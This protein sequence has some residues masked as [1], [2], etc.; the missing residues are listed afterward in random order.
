MRARTLYLHVGLPKTASTFLQERVFPQ[1][2]GLR[3]ACAPEAALFDAADPRA[4]HRVVQ[5]ALRR[6]A[7]VWD[8]MGDKIF[9]ALFGDRDACEAADWDAL[10]S[11]E[12]IGRIAN[13]PETFAAHLRAMAALGRAW[14]FP[15]TV[16][17]CLLRRQDQWIGS[18]YAQTSDA[19][20][21]AGQAHFEE[22]IARLLDPAAARHRLGTLLDYDGVVAAMEAA[23]GVEATHVM[24]YER[25][26]ADPDAFRRGL[27]T[28]LDRDPD[29]LAG[30]PAWSRR[31]NARSTAD[32]GWRLR[33]RHA[34]GPLGRLRAR[35][36][37]ERGSVRL[38]PALSARIRESYGPGN[39]RLAARR[40]DL[41]LEEH[42]YLPAP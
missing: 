28:A 20:A 30:A 22:E 21:G 40:P 23:L 39:R 9:H 8:S 3:A 19:V 5:A 31:A 11:E 27:M 25:L 26:A 36:A 32:E 42:G 10:I 1:L 16:G 35:L 2:P 13:R 37:G 14:G 33:P 24:P 41:G 29:L 7:G 17:L 18:H 12:A 4:G 38:T 34:A 15:R 6:S